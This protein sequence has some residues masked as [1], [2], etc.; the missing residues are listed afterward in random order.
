MTLRTSSSPPEGS[1]E[2]TTNYPTPLKQALIR[3]HDEPKQSTHFPLFTNLC[4]L[5]KSIV[6]GWPEPLNKI[7]WGKERNRTALLFVEVAFILELCSRR[8]LSDSTSDS[9]SESIITSY[10]IQMKAMADKSDLTL[11]KVIG[12]GDK[13]LEH[14]RLWKIWLKIRRRGHPY[15]YFHSQLRQALEPFEPP[16]DLRQ[17]AEQLLKDYNSK[18]PVP[19]LNADGAPQIATYLRKLKNGPQSA[20]ESRNDHPKPGEQTK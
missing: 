4:K 2:L 1:S 12:D 3:L 18:Q 8:A 20:P 17:A 16:D 9:N 7:D 14:P 13:Y 5:A 10:K 15:E 11:K 6:E 19:T